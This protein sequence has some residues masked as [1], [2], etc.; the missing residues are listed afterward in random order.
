MAIS[1]LAGPQQMFL[2]RRAPQ[3]SAGELLRLRRQL[4][5]A[6]FLV[7]L[8]HVVQPVEYDFRDCSAA[9]TESITFASRPGVCARPSCGC[10]AALSRVLSGLGGGCHRLREAA[11]KSLPDRKYAGETACATTT[12]QWFEKHGRAGIQPASGFFSSL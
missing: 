2:R 10:H 7:F 4:L 6:F 1:E 8:E 11:R 12:N 3:C 5:C 9:R